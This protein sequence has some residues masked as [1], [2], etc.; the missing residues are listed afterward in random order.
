MMISI[1]LILFCVLIVFGPLLWFR[2]QGIKQDGD[3][4]RGN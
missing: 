1:L 2:W 3:R 4:E